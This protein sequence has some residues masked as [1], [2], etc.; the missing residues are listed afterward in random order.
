MEVNISICVSDMFFFLLLFLCG[1]PNLHPFKMSAT[2]V[3][4]KKKTFDTFTNLFTLFVL[5]VMW[6]DSVTSHFD[7]L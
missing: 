5:I 7:V 3:I 4:K 1:Y 6:Y 2:E